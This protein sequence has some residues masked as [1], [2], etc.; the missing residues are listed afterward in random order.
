MEYLKE[1]GITDEEIKKLKNRYNEEIINFIEKNKLFIIN[2]IKYLFSENIKCIY[3]LMI[4]NIK[5]FLETQIALK[6]KIEKMKKE[7]LNIKEIQ[8]RLLQDI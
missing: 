4:N 8:M 5:I 1:Y 3:L 7:K 6:R 2:T